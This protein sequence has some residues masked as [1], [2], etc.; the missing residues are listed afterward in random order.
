MARKHNK[1]RMRGI[2]GGGDKTEGKD[3]SQRQEDRIYYYII[4]QYILYIIK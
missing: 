4:L 2:K 3:P 1:G